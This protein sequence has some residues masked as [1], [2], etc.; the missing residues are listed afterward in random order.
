MHAE[1]KGA[2]LA[3]FKQCTGRDK[4][5]AE[6]NRH[7]QLLH[8]RIWKSQSNFTLERFIAQHQNTVLDLLHTK[9]HT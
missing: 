6:I 5:K 3:L 4:W 7:E 8:R 1:W 2:W 9:T